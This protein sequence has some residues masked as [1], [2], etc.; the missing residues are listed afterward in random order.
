MAKHP[1][2]DRKFRKYLRGAITHDM[3]LATLASKTLVREENSDTLTEKA[4]LSSVSLRWALSNMTPTASAGPILVGIAHSDYSATE[5]EEWIENQGSWEQGDQVAQE[6]G[7][8]KI[9]QVGVFAEPTAVGVALN[10]NE[11][12]AISTKCGWILTTG[13]TVAFWAYNTGTAALAT[14]SPVVTC[15][16]HAN[17]WPN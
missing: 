2:R 8:R 12:K 9:R 1:K 13:Q 4:W 15:D 7:R 14:T 17:L 3:A 5:I 16:G 6:I 10:L 11:G